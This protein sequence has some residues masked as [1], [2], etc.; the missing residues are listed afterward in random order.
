MAS[1]DRSYILRPPSYLDSL[2]FDLHRLL[3]EIHADR[4]LGLVGEASSGETECEAGLPDVRV[5]NHDDLKDPRLDGQLEGGGELQ[6]GQALLAAT[7]APGSSRL[8]TGMPVPRSSSL[9]LRGLV[10][11]DAGGEMRQAWRL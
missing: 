1:I 9:R 4:G 2:S 11:H 7:G 5:S 10:S 3:S 8:H 6:G